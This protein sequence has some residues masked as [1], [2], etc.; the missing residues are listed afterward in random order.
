VSLFRDKVVII[1]GGASGIG[2]ALCEELANRGAIV[3]VADINTEGAEQVASSISLKGGQAYP[4][5]LNVVNQKDV[6]TVIEN[7]AKE[8]GRLDYMFNNA[9]I[10]FGGEMRDM[11][12]DQWRKI[13]DINLNG[14]LYGTSAAYS[15]MVRQGF[16]H[17][18]NTASGAGL[19]PVPN[20]TAY[21]TTKFGVVGLSTSLRAEGT[22]LGVKVSVVCPGMVDTPIFEATTFA[23]IKKKEY[24]AS[25]PKYLL[26][27]ATDTARVILRGVERNKAVIIDSLYCRI[28]WWTYK[29]VPGLT[30]YMNRKMIQ[31]TR[32]KFRANEL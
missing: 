19:F 28:M 16:G 31:D 1:T 18:V 21:A 15:L 11:N 14:V 5:S 22:D 7:T 32:E 13:F 6:E 29:F 27:N 8:Y 17:I 30:Y 10:A 9:G 12:M 3:I 26:K 25:F 20:S 24:L 4:V 23:K 2:R